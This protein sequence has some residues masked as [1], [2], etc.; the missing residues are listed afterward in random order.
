MSDAVH[1]PMSPEL[2]PAEVDP[3]SIH[4][5]W[6]G[7]PSP[8]VRWHFHNEY[9]LHLIVASKGRV[10]VGDHVGEFNPGH[11]VMTGP[12]LPHNW[13][14]Q[15]PPGDVVEMRDGVIQFRKDLVQSMASSAP[16]VQ[17]LLPLLD[18]ARTGIE[19]SSSL[20]A[21]AEVWFDDIIHSEGV[22]RIGLLLELLER[23]AKERHY[24][25]LST[26]PR[27]LGKRA[28]VLAKLERVK[29]HIT[30]HH[31]DNIHVESV[32]DHFGMSQPSFSRF[33][34]KATGGSFAQYLNSV[35]IAHACQLLSISEQPITEICF[36]VGFNNVA[37]FNRRF[38]DLKGLTPSEYRKIVA[39][40]HR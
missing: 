38:R 3:R 23:L 7:Y 37:N 35:R 26:A 30:E 10:F 12:H 31:A 33:F 32:A 1:S 27:G 36:T 22:R 40:G 15:T 8:L 20:C 16:E 24:R 21:E 14:S 9:E 17:K 4:A 5:F 28:D 29:T 2:G 6:H 18:R 39:L 11:L 13:I 19:F 25:S 34:S